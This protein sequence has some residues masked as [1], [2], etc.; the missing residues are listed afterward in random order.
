MK[1]AGLW[2]VHPPVAGL[3]GTANGSKSGS[4]RK[5]TAEDDDEDES[6]DENGPNA[7]RIHS[8]RRCT[9]E[10]ASDN[11]HARVRPVDERLLTRPDRSMVLFDR[12]IDRRRAGR[13]PSRY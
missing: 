1:L 11:G 10:D 3:K 12:L 9:L 2:G 5:G 4:R 8:V 6:E 7:K 13:Q